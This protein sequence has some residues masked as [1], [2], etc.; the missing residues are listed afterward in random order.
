MTISAITIYMCV[1]ACRF[2]LFADKEEELQKWW[3]ALEAIK[4]EG[5]WTVDTPAPQ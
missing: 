5:T 3:N 2:Y 4:P 1:C